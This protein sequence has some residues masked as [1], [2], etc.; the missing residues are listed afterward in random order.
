MT[1]TDAA[2]LVELGRP[3]VVGQLDIPALKPGQVLVDVA[4]S[5]VCH[6]QLL[7]ARG[8]RGADAYLPHLLGH[9]GSGVVTAIGPGV[10]R[11]A[12]GDQVIMSWIQASGANV[13]GT[14]YGWRD[15]TVNAGAVTTFGR[16][17]VVS[18]NRVTRMP[19]GLSLQQGA[20]LGCAVATG[21]GAVVNTAEARA[22]QSVV[23]F[24]A[25]GVGLSAISGAALAG[26]L[27]VVAVDTN[28]ARLELA[29]AMG[30]TDAIVGGRPETLADIR[31]LVAD[32]VDVV[33]EATGRPSV[34]ADALA[35]VRPRG[36]VAVVVGNSRHG[37]R[38]EIDP[39][40]L[41]M[42]KRLVGSWGGD[43]VPDR[44]FPRYA[45]FISA[46]RLRLDLVI[47]RSYGLDQI[48]AALDDLEMGR[49][50]RP[51][52]AMQS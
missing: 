4:F 11:V 51:L 17:S 8:Y 7:E 5:G 26:C 29:R 28:A 27:P 46:G 49:V 25:G 40:E 34:M 3:L 43:T 39:R 23:V 37:E 33:I 12:P 1:A 15:R 50:A 2:I 19:A 36:G 30:A 9:E 52:I 6:T 22:G 44:D 47:E 14:T 13:S 48:N 31:Q 35:L 42:G 38:L 32:G 20:L 18:E 24:G 16:R 45:R 10:T 41:N 21:L